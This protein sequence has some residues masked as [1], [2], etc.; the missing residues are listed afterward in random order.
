MFET[1]A[2]PRPMDQGRRA[3][4]F[5]LSLLLNL[6][7][8]GGLLLLGQRVVEQVAPDA[9]PEPLTLVE[10]VDPPAPGPA[11]GPKV[12][13]P[14]AK[15]AS[16]PAPAPTPTPEVPPTPA[17]GVATDALSDAA[18]PPESSGGPGGEGEGEGE[19]GEGGEGGGGGGDVRAVHWSEVRVRSRVEPRYPEAAKQLGLD[20]G[21]CALRIQIDAR[22]EP[23]DIQVRSCN[24][25]FEASALEAAW[26][27]R[28]YPMKVDGVAVPAAFDL[29]IVYK[30]R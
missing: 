19:G 30:L 25:V 22:G 17:L 10:L 23:T 28:F 20:E 9:G 3:A 5:A 24:K 13:K 21:R 6:S 12:H 26:K 27:W 15:A 2:A 16:T 11:L 29:A 4:S 7:V 18:P 14:S 8:L 1:V